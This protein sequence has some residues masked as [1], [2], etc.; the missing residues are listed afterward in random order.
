MLFIYIEY[1]IKN[2]KQNHIMHKIIYCREKNVN[3]L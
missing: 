2:L 3:K 1:N